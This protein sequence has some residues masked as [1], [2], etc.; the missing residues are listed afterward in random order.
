MIGW[1]P[2]YYGIFFEFNGE[3]YV[4]GVGGDAELFAALNSDEK[5]KWTVCELEVQ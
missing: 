5:Y 3:Q 1:N 4:V 2:L